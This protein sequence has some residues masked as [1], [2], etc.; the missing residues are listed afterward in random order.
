MRPCSVTD[1]RLECPHC[2]SG[3]LCIDTVRVKMLAAGVVLLA[4]I[5]LVLGE[6]KVGPLQGEDEY[7][8]VARLEMRCIGCG[9]TSVLR[10]RD[11]SGVTRLEWESR[12]GAR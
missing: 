8:R 7:S 10:L 9:E 4:S 3:M 1:G 6:V 5:T 2:G 12:L 11:V